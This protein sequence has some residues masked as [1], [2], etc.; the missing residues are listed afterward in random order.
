MADATSAESSL[1]IWGIS[2]GVAML[3]AHVTLGWMRQSQK[4]PGLRQNW[5]ALLLAAGVLGT[6]ICSTMLLS[7]AAA[8]L[9]FPI[10]YMALM[11]PAIWAAAVLGSVPVAAWVALNQ[12]WFSLLGAGML[13]AAVATAVQV[14]WIM[15]AGFRPG[16]VWRREFVAAAAVLATVGLSAGLW[17]AF[18]F[19]AQESRRRTL[20]RVGA[21]MLVA[22]SIVAGQ[23]L[24][25]YGA[26]LPSQVGSVYLRQ[27]PGAI[28]ALAAGV[29]VPLVL[30][31]MA[32]DLALRSSR[33]RR[34]R[35][36]TDPSVKFDPQRRRKR[37]HRVRSL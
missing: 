29:F 6:G 16:V 36:S 34:R 14:A 7:L 26:S 19:V 15:A 18:S 33:R 10:G 22:L 27:L 32:V 1:L 30:S 12:R 17:V 9:S 20:W 24:V 11:A 37:R 25:V 2:A 21:A 4:E 8:A 3:T 35:P 28:L 5:R 31:A 23:E 13:L